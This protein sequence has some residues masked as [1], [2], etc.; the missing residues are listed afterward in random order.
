MS[1]WNSVEPCELHNLG[2][3][4][5]W[6][7]TPR[8]MTSS[9][10]HPNKPGG[11]QLNAGTEFD[12]TSHLVKALL[13]ERILWQMECLTIWISHFTVIELTDTYACM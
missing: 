1:W 11:P 7:D 3:F 13:E 6:G 4:R 5:L 8:Q 10:G 2:P 12:T 9:F